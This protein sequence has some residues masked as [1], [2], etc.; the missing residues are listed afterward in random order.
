M[1]NVWI[2]LVGF[3]LILSL[4][5]MPVYADDI[6]ISCTHTDVN[7]NGVCQ[8]PDCGVQAVACVET[9][10]TVEYM[11]AANTL[12]WKT[13]HMNNNE[14]DDIYTITLLSDIPSVSLTILAD[15]V[16][17]DLNGFRMGYTVGDFGNIVY[18]AEKGNLTIVDSSAEGTGYMYNPTGPVVDFVRSSV[19]ESE[20]VLTIKQG[21]FESDAWITF[22]LGAGTLYIEGGTIIGDFMA[23]DG[24][25]TGGRFSLDPTEALTDEYEAVLEG[26]YYVV[27]KVSGGEQTFH[28]GD[29]NHDG[30]T[31]SSDAVAIL[32]H[33][34]GYEVPGFFEDTADF[35][36]GG[37]ADSS[38]A[39]AILRKLA[40]Y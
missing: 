18:L 37:Y 32:R 2:K 11:F 39:I 24:E 40:G 36:G 7:A 3:V 5:V 13:I 6:I 33:L 23:G 38:D 1:K 14:T 31:D 15:T 4:L 19:S 8:N 26:E 20:A 12:A 34:A 27:K 21:T 16:T 28:R 17:L 25:I 10:D 9:A 29:A 35:N 30:K 22:W